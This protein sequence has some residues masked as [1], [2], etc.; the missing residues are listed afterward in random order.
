[1]RVHAIELRADDLD[2]RGR[3]REASGIE[4]RGRMKRWYI[5][6]IVLLASG[7]VAVAIGFVVWSLRN[8]PSTSEAE[9]IL[10]KTLETPATAQ[11]VSVELVDETP[12]GKGSHYTL[13]HIVVDAQN[14]FGA[15]TRRS[16]CVIHWDVG[17]KYQWNGKFG[18]QKCGAPPTA[19]EIAI[20]KKLNDWPSR[21]GAPTTTGQ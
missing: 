15:L 13:T 1:M 4:V 16:Y 10:L 5:A 3:K 7:L 8:G 14:T 11:F 20:L 17:T 6:V 21:Q 19:N 9:E 12:L 18:V 2:E